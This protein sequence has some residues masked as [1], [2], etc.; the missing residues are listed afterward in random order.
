MVVNDLMIKKAINY[1]YRKIIQD[2][3]LINNEKV[4]KFDNT[5]KDEF[6]QLEEVLE[7]YLSEENQKYLDKIIQ[8]IKQI[9]NKYI[10]FYDSLQ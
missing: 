1:D 2:N 9:I 7:N 6:E 4:E 5:Y 8:L 3:Y 10:L